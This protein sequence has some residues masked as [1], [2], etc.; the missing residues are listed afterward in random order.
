ML[1]LM[2]E[3]KT[4]DDGILVNIQLDRKSVSWYLYSCYFVPTF[5]RCRW[6]HL[7]L[8]VVPVISSE[9]IADVV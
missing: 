6:W 5:G 4:L 7:C 2:S 9:S 3:R 1:M 8:F